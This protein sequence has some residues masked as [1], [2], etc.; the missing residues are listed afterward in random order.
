[1][2]TTY[3]FVVLAENSVGL[4]ALSDSI[5]ILHAVPPDQPNAPSTANNDQDIIITWVAP[6]AN[7]TPITGYKVLWVTSDGATFSEETT[8]CDASSSIDTTCTIPQSSLTLSPFSLGLFDL[9][10]AK[11]IAVNIKGESVESDEGQCA[12]IITVPDAPIN[13]VEDTS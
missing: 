13:L 11:V 8:N 1:M 12:I 9:V 6:D 2:G 5:V 4:S 10:K 3:E 7:G